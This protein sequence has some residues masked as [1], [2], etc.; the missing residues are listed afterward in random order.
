MA[1]RKGQEKS[2]E[3]WPGTVLGFTE[4][5]FWV[6]AEE[7]FAQIGLSDHHQDETG[8]LIAVEL[9]HVGDLIEKGE[10]FG[11]VESVRTVQELIAPVSGT[12]VASN[13]E[14][15]DNPSLANEDP[16]HEGWLI[17]VTLANA[18]ELHS[19]MGTEEYEDFAA[20]DDDG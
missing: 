3:A 17:E 6:R 10:P 4:D 20:Q 13:T 16:Y 12:V 5:H 7:N 1:Q 19:L 9:P 8:D 15:E 14:L 11:E 18:E 2:Q